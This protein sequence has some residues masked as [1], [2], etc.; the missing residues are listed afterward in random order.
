MVRAGCVKPLCDLLS[1]KD[2][3][4]IGVVLEALENIL[5]VGEKSVK[6]QKITENP[7]T[8]VIEEAEG[9]DKLEDLQN[10]ENEDIYNKVVKILETYFNAEETENE[11]ITPNISANQ[12]TFTFGTSAVQI[13]Q[14]GFAF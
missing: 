4:L 3:K 7:Y 11:N 8:Q 10:I 5:Y 2:V 1:L 6:D 12:Q 9:L 13:P 14:S